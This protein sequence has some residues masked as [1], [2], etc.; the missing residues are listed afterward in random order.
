MI[1]WSLVYNY[2]WR[3]YKIYKITSQELTTLKG[4]HALRHSNLFVSTE[5][6]DKTGR[7]QIFVSVNIQVSAPKNNIIIIHKPHM[8]IKMKCGKIKIWQ[9]Y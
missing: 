3:S 9:D 5:T 1:K 8:L 6:H 7:Y 2:V 4:S